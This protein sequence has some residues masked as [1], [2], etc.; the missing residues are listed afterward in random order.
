M[1]A[2]KKELTG[3]SSARW[4]YAIIAGNDDQLRL[5]RDGQYRHVEGL[6]A[7]I[8]TIEAR[9]AA[10][11]DDTLTVAERK[12]RRKTKAV[13]GCP[14]RVN[15]SRSSGGCNICGPNLPELNGTGQPVGSM[16]SR[17]ANGSRAR[18]STWPLP[19]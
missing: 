13:K 5:A 4:A 17:A 8:A 11:T 18:A 12:A 19:A 15:D 7:A 16:S 6:R 1:N 9:L 3:Q 10:P 14:L 2:R